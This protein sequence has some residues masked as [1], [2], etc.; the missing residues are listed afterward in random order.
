MFVTSSGVMVEV[1]FFA[2]DLISMHSVLALD[3]TAMAMAPLGLGQK[4]TLQ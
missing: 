1:D 3:F 4:K 2:I